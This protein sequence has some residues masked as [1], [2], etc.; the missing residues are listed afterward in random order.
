MKTRFKTFVKQYIPY[1]PECYD[2]TLSTCEGCKISESLEIVEKK[3][4]ELV[5]S[6]ITLIIFLVI[7][8]LFF[9][10]IGG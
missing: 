8:V 10:A 3:T 9:D 7:I 2:C 5:S 6:C 4:I 1:E